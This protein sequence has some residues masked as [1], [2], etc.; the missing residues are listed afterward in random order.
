MRNL[1]FISEE[2]KETICKKMR[3]MDD[4]RWCVIPN[5]LL[6]DYKINNTLHAEV[7]EENSWIYNELNDFLFQ[8]KENED[9]VIFALPNN[10]L[11]VITELL[12]NEKKSTYYIVAEHDLRNK[13]SITEDD[14]IFLQVDLPR[15]RMVQL[16]LANHCNLNCKGCANYSNLE[17]NPSF[18]DFVTFEK[19]LHQLKKFFWGIEKIKLMGGEPLLNKCIVS[20]LKIARKLF[21]DAEI[22]IGTNGLCIRQQEER[23]FDEM[24]ELHIK[25]VISIYPGTVSL[26]N[27]IEKLL[28]DKD[29]EYQVYKFKGDFMKYMSEKPVWDKQ[30]G[31]KHCPARECHCMENGWLAICGRPL[32]IHRLNDKFKVNI[33]DDCGKWNL[34]NTVLN[35]WELDQLLRTPI[36]TCQYCG[37]RQYF[38]WEIRGKNGE[39]EDW[40]VS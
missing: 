36:T 10:T 32:Y 19:D 27:E 39:K 38:R 7:N 11:K 20:Y 17:D 18:Y 34:Y 5:A 24:K 12:K 2:G 26:Q 30:E 3:L 37:P 40:I 9:R 25:F 14:F 8:N 4:I 22:E 31:Y 23:L 15:L 1:V 21:P 16:N 28:T 29:V 35:P 6:P 33:P 13:D